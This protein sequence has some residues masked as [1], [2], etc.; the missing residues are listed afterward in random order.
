MTA[1]RLLICQTPIKLLCK[2]SFTTRFNF[3]VTPK[4]VRAEKL[5]AEIEKEI[6]ELHKKSASLLRCQVIN[7]IKN[8][9]NVKSILSVFVLIA[10]RQLKSS[11][12]IFITKADKGYCTVVMNKKNYDEKLRKQLNDKQ[13]YI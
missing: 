6:S 12:N 2:K 8:P 4:S 9:P 5:C 1:I 3:A 13:T 11:S 7:A 10:V